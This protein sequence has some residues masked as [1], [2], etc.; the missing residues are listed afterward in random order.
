MSKLYGTRTHTVWGIQF[1]KWQF[2][3]SEVL[4]KFYTFQAL[5]DSFRSDGKI[6]TLQGLYPYVEQAPSLNGT[7]KDSFVLDLGK[8]YETK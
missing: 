6:T 2:C 8:A 5:L 7:H 4:E 1:G 3:F